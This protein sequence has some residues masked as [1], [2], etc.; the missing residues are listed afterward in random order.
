M[1]LHT[2]ITVLLFV[3]C[4]GACSVQP[5]LSPTATQQPTN[6][7]RPTLVPTASRGPTLFPTTT[8]QP[9]VSVQP[10]PA[11][12][13]C[14]D[15]DNGA[16]DEDG[17][18]CAG[19]DVDDC[20][21][22]DDTDFT[23]GDMCCLCGGGYQSTTQLPTSAPTS[24]Q[25]PTV[26]PAPTMMYDVST[27]A[28]LEVCE[29][30][31]GAWMSIAVASITVTNEIYLVTP[32]EWRI[33]GNAVEGGAVLDGGG[34]TQLFYVRNG[35]RL[36]LEH[37]WLIN[38]GNTKDGGAIRV[39]VVSSEVTVTSCT[40]SDNTA[41]RMGGAAFTQ[42][43]AKLR[44]MNSTLIR[45]SAGQTGGAVESDSHGDFKN[46]WFISNSCSGSYAQD[47]SGHGGAIN[48]RDG[49]VT[50][51]TFQFNSAV[52]SGGALRTAGDVAV[53]KC[54][55]DTNTA[56]M[57]GGGVYTT[58]GDLSI[59]KNSVFSNC[60]A[61][62]DGGGI[63][64]GEGTI[65]ITIGENSSFSSC[66][67]STG[68]GAAVF[69]MVSTAVEDTVIRDFAASAS[70]SSVAA[71]YHGASAPNYLELRSGVTFESVDLLYFDSFEPSTVVVM[72]LHS[73]ASA[74]DFRSGSLLTC[75]NAS[76]G[77]FCP[78]EY[79]SDVTMGIECYCFPDDIRTDPSSGASC[80]SSA[81]MPQLVLGF[82]KTQR[83]TLNKDDTT[84]IT[85]L[86]FSNT[87]DVPLAWNLAVTANNEML[88]W[89]LSSTSGTLS[90]GLSQQVTIS[91]NLSALQARV[92][93][94]ITELT[95]NTSSPIPTPVP[96]SATTVVVVRTAVSASP[97]AMRS[98]VTLK[99]VSTITA[100]STVDFTVVP[101]D[102]TGLVILD[103][104][105]IAYTAQLNAP[106]STVIAC[107]V[108]YDAASDRHQGTC[109]PPSLVAGP[110]AIDVLDAGG[111][112]VGGSSHA[113]HI[114]ACPETY[115][116]DPEDSVCKCA[117]GRFDQGFSC[118][119]CPGGTIAQ[120]AGKDTCTEC[121][122]HQTSGPTRTHCEC[123][124]GYFLEDEECMLCPD[125]VT[126]DWNS[127]VADWV[128]APGVWRLSSVS[129]D[130]RDCRFGDASCPGVNAS[131]DGCTTRGFGVWPH[132][133]CGY[134]GPTCA[135]CDAS[136][137]VSWAA[138]RCEGCGS[139]DAHTPSIVLGCM[140]VFL[141]GVGK[142]FL[143]SQTFKTLE[144]GKRF[145]RLVRLGRTKAG[146]LFYVCQVISSFS[147]ISS[148]TGSK[149]HPEPA[150]TFASALGA[151]NADFLQF[152]PMTCL[153]S[154]T[155][156]FYWRMAL[157]SLIPIGAIFLL[158]LWPLGCLT[159][160]KP[161]TLAMRTAA[162][163][164]LLL[165]E[166]VTPS[167][168]TTVMQTFACS[169]FDDGGDDKVWF[170][171][172]ELT[173]ACD[174][175][176][177]AR[178][179]KWVAV[180]GV[181]IAGYAVGVPLLLFSALYYNRDEINRVQ[182]ALKDNDLQQSDVLSVKR[183]VEGFSANG[184][185]GSI[186]ASVKGSM[187]FLVKRFEK[188]SPGR[189]YAGTFLLVL[190]ILQT[191]VLVLIP[192]QELQAAAASAL[193]IFGA[194]VLRE[195]RP[196]RR[197]SDNEVAVAAQYCVFLW[198]FSILLRYMIQRDATFNT[199]DS[200]I[201]FTMGVGLI[202]ATAAVFGFALWRA[203]SELKLLRAEQG[204]SIEIDGGDSSSGRSEQANCADGAEDEPTEEGDHTNSAAGANGLGG[205]ALVDVDAPG[206]E[207]PPSLDDGKSEDDKGDASCIGCADAW[208]F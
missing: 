63:Y 132:C 200:N 202:L 167:V 17:D 36:M 142:W 140:L 86:F 5:T 42:Y 134:V 91:L 40:L 14:F 157:K 198:T 138:D 82:E 190:R 10:S 67:A 122:I 35:A 149:G 51:C 150:A 137:F 165:L 24:S 121:P 66:V 180:A 126:C 172:A 201:L 203:F 56:A 3:L 1:M 155:M 143:G 84:G 61:S 21:E 206:A 139:D 205:V 176:G 153:V 80:L 162:K 187:L 109:D 88:L 96:I 178:R 207:S 58:N 43:F 19:Y 92:E 70:D 113:F 94:Y 77:D 151:T 136:Y 197:N 175:G 118:S 27:Y 9:T 163:L 12:T 101:V 181:F 173:L 119:L 135:V 20:G 53:Q 117:A 6:S 103:A 160:R 106:G 48:M 83:L 71:F 16:L 78:N 127:T 112:L 34:G 158:W 147:S 23:A 28:E 59:E 208:S 69:S 110:F 11:P 87:G 159:F 130:L 26:T 100:S 185:R 183:M 199:A 195:L 65:S 129:K 50:D 174:K 188:Y 144:L 46:C 64:A 111:S 32:Y 164:T 154:A 76:M 161:H 105:Q 99:N 57:N 169:G 191:S 156:D 114:A 85:N 204:R 49:Q 90:P 141:A 33:T 29:T 133:G 68:N 81:N 25:V 179:R 37:L 171:R 60:V 54:I 125:K 13:T 98:Y 18:G 74:N 15:S 44:L 194:N 30:L 124:T 131:D 7:V 102:S 108:A 93:D 4:R 89:V 73:S 186:V 115:V 95:L 38:G 148:D 39:R 152:V 97:D 170:M 123:E 22:G 182:E 145:K 168:A 196:F 72:N 189:W 128:L 52:G 2:R 75:R 8:R 166:I 104:S 47:G 120:T 116:L 184:R 31:P 192:S 146:I 177:G 55:F 45:N 193:A 62:V 79:C 41:I 107:S